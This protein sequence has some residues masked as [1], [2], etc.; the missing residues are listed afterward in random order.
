MGKDCLLGLPGVSVVVAASGHA[1]LTGSV[2][3][4]CTASG[5][6]V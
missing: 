3:A 5:Q 4:G 2:Q 6:T 1:E